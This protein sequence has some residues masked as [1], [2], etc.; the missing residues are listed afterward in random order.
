MR[1]KGTR[2]RKLRH[3]CKDLK[4]PGPSEGVETRVLFNS[5]W[6]YLVLLGASV[7]GSPHWG[8]GPTSAPASC[9]TGA[10]EAASCLLSLSIHL[11]VCPASA[12]LIQP[13]GVQGF[14]IQILLAVPRWLSRCG[15][16]SLP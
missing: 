12:A 8:L 5:L 3:R 1:G 14:L 6:S 7:V 15:T 16:P 9:R 11:W 2:L 13:L 10:S 4:G